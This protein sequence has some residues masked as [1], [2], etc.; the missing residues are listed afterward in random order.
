MLCDVTYRCL[1]SIHLVYGI[2]SFLVHH[3]PR[4]L[5]HIAS[6]LYVRL[7]SQSVTLL[8]HVVM[9]PRWLA[10]EILE[11]ELTVRSG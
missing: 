5:K 7:G 3:S 1:S 4:R 6:G 11:A 9:L 10:A 2:A 8:S